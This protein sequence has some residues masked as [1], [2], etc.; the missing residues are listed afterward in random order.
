MAGTPAPRFS[1]T[2]GSKVQYGVDG[3]LIVGGARVTNATPD[4]LWR[5]APALN[6]HDMSRMFYLW[7]DFTNQASATASS[8]MTWTAMNDG[9]TG[10]PAYQTAAGGVFNTVTAAADN[11]YSGYRSVAKIFKFAAGKELWFEARFK[12]AEATVLESTQWFGFSDTVTTGGMQSDALGPL[13]SYD[14]A[15]LW[16]TP[17]TA[18]SWNFETSNAGT[19][20]TTST[21]GTQV[22]DTWTRVGMYFDGAATTGNITPYMDVGAG[23][24][25]FTPKAVTLASMDEMYLIWGVKAG[26]TAAAETLQLDYIKAL[27]LR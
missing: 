24:V 17:E 23:W 26:P 20:S 21:L 16:K 2:A 9:G 19:Q 10:T 18:L 8:V 6:D 5:S 27:Q 13:A 3:S 1:L 14:G 12:C 15:I 11:D 7:D 4:P 22:T 25:A